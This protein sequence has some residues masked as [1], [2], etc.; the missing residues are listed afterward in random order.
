[1]VVVVTRRPPT[2]R[3]EPP[4]LRSSGARSEVKIVAIGASTEAPPR[5][6]RSCRS[7]VPVRRSGPHRP[8]HRRRLRPRAGGLARRRLQTA[9]RDGLAESVARARDG[10]RGSARPAP[11]RVPVGPDPSDRRSPIGGHRPSATHLFRSVSAAY[12]PNAVGLILTGIGADG[13]EGLR[14]LRQA[15]ERSG[16]GPR[17]ERGLRDAGSG[18]RGRPGRSGGPTGFGG[19][20]PRGPGARRA[21]SGSQ[22]RASEGGR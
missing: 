7:S 18:R 8:A 4:Q 15:G 9:R 3:R 12:G 2:I 6:R 21:L 5:W 16:S 1:M 13:C 10:V 19:P 14:T 20:G 17:V 11:G 22:P